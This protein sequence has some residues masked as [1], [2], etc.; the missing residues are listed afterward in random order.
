[1]RG[2][3]GHPPAV[4][5]SLSV[6][7]THVEHV[8]GDAACPV[9]AVCE[10]AVVL[11]CQTDA[12]ARFVEGLVGGDENVFPTEIFIPLVHF[13]SDGCVERS[14]AV[15]DREQPEDLEEVPGVAGRQSRYL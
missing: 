4:V 8:V 9:V 13:A 15:W 5:G 10:C 11:H 2:R 3:S 14:V 12:A 1:V 6:V 7:G